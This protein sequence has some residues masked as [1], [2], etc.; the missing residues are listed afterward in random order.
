MAGDANLEIGLRW[1]RQRDALWANLR[2]EMAGNRDEWGQPDEPLALDMTQLRSLS[3][4]SER[5]GRA[6]AEMVLR[7]ADIGPF[8]RNAVQTSQREGLTLHLRLHI[9]APAQYHAVR[10]ET[11]RDPQ[12]NTRIATQAGI[13]MS[14]YLSSPDWRPVPARE[15]RDLRALIVVAG[16]TDLAK[17]KPN[18]RT[19][20]PV[21]IDPELEQARTALADFQEVD[22]LAR[23][24][25][26]LAQMLDAVET[27]VDVLYLV[28]HGAL[29]GDVPVLYLE[30]PDRTAD[31]VDGRKLVELLMA[32]ERRPTVVML[33]SCQSATRGTEVWT[34]DDGELSALGPRLAGAGV[35]S[36]VAMQ[37]DISMTTAG[38][39]APAF[40]S[41]LAEHGFVDRAM[42]AARRGV[43]ARPDWWAPVLYSRL[44][45]GRTYYKP[46][47]TARADNTWDNLR[48]QLATANLLPVLGPGL[49]DSIL[50]SRQDIARRWVERWQMPLAAHNQG[51]LAQ[52]A[53][54]LRVRST[55][56]DVRAQLLEH[57]NTEIARRQ[58]RAEPGHHFHDLSSNGQ[59]PEDAIREVGRRLRADDPGDPY[60]VAAALP[61]NVYVTTTWTDLLQDALR[62]VDPPREPVTMA[63][64]WH[65]RTDP[66][67]L[68][69]YEEPTIE[70][71]LVYHL[72]GRLEDRWSLVLTEDDYFAWYSAW[73]QRRGKEVPEVVKSAFVERALLLLGFQLDDWDFK[74]LFNGI[75]SFEGS[76]RRRENQHVGVQLSPENQLIEPDAAQDYLESYFG[77][78]KVN[79]FW[80]TTPT[81]LKEFC[82]RMG[83]AT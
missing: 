50:G 8:Y 78:D 22:E 75:K 42:A 37:G 77:D 76:E 56:G 72:F 66:E 43:E 71:P 33:C 27:G 83:L 52:V 74:V 25:A 73:L 79:I 57:L 20:A 63:F 49:A 45:S 55:A 62:D 34:G 60:N 23:A 53:Q 3:A 10:W 44:R 6:L 2:F 54:F 48:A 69:N 7:P 29:V 1:D 35:A 41:E 12:S 4:D 5:Y 21:E 59:R 46:E 64:A 70:R 13:L 61:V 67:A 38:T 39:F 28:C 16:P 31:R 80:G 40:F 14:R 26:G 32:L 11:L 36:V 68:Q 58:R 81:F 24:D 47:F 65:K 17:H 51:D 82:A 30:H 19:L 18:E 15:K 9:T